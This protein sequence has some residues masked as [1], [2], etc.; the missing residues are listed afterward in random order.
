MK[1]FYFVIMLVT[2]LVNSTSFNLFRGI[3]SIFKSSITNV[4]Q[5]CFHEPEDCSSEEGENYIESKQSIYRESESIDIFVF[6]KG[7]QDY[8]S[9]QQKE[10]GFHIRGVRLYKDHA[11]FTLVADVSRNMERISFS[12]EDGEYHEL[13]FFGIRENGYLYVSPFS[14]ESCYDILYRKAYDDRK[15]SFAEYERAMISLYSRLDTG[16]YSEAVYVESEATENGD[17]SMGTTVNGTI[18][19]KDDSNNYHPLQ[20]T[21]VTVF[22]DATSVALGTTYTDA[23]GYYTISSSSSASSV[24][25]RASGQTAYVK[26]TNASNI[27]YGINSAVY[28]CSGIVTINLDFSMT[29]EAG[30]ALQLLQGANTLARFATPMGG[31]TLDLVRIVY[32]RTDNTCFSYSNSDKTIYA[33][34]DTTHT[35]KSY[36]AWDVIMHEYGHYLEHKIGLITTGIGGTHT[37]KADLPSYRQSLGLSYDKQT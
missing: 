24:Y 7:C 25:I 4:S 36:A 3:H 29:T 1:M 11:I 31:Y 13:S 27:L 32:P 5:T 22:D 14:F 17:R 19:W 18:R 26:V 28:N 33:Y 2:L 30:Q 10:E 9:L 34:K 15:I 37:I 8:S 6:I 35:L 16:L 21:R 20:Y 23:A 12:W